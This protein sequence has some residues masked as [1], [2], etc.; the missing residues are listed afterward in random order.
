MAKQ[1][2]KNQQNISNADIRIRITGAHLHSLHFIVLVQEVNEDKSR[3][4]PDRPL[5][6]NASVLLNGPCATKL[7]KYGTEQKCAYK[8]KHT[9]TKKANSLWP[10]HTA[11]MQKYCTQHNPPSHPTPGKRGAL[12]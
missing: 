2:F 6:E 7:L 4:D 3:H 5:K 1:I 9:C 10:R 11:N 12:C 8:H